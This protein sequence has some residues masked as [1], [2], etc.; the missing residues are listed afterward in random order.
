MIG[1]II[2]AKALIEGYRGRFRKNEKSSNCRFFPKIPYVI[3]LTLNVFW[4]TKNLALITH[5]MFFEMHKIFPKIMHKMFPLIH[6]ISPKKMHKIISEIRKI[7]PKIHNLFSKIHKIFPK[8]MLQKF[9]NLFLNSSSQS[10]T[11]FVLQMTTRRKHSAL[12][13]HGK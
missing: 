10:R 1:I 12:R 13:T 5:Q 3:H 9:F 6:K 8:K 2:T 11:V 7:S 4:N